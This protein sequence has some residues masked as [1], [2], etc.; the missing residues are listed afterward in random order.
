MAAMIERFELDGFVLHSNRSCKTYSLGQLL[1]K[2]ELT[3]LTGRPA[4]VLEAD[5]VDPRY[6]DAT[7]VAS[8]V[9]TFLEVLG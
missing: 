7:R 1:I 2:R 9:S 8:Q 5:M 6:Y 4:L 3:R